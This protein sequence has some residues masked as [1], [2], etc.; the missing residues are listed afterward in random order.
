MVKY[1]KRAQKEILADYTPFDTK[2]TDPNEIYCPPA[3]KKSE[4]SPVRKVSKLAAPVSQ[5]NSRRNISFSS[6]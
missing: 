4:V 1:M 6:K 5:S 2:V 3:V